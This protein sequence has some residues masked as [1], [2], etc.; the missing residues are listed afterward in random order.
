MSKIKKAAKGAL[1]KKTGLDIPTAL[2]LPKNAPYVSFDIFDTLIKRTVADPKDVFL[3]LEKKLGIPDFYK[4]RIDAEKEARRK[5]GGEV[6]LQEIYQSFGGL[7]ENEIKELSEEEL[8]TE[9]AVCIPNKQLMGFYRYCIKSKKV[10]LISD[11][12]LPREMIEKILYNCGVTGFDKIYI[13]CDIGLTKRSGKLYKFVLDDLCIVSKELV[14]IGND[15]MADYIS[16]KII[17]IN[18]VKIKTTA[19]HLNNA[20]LE[21][22]VDDQNYGG[23]FA[24]V[25]SIISNNNKDLQIDIA[26]IE[27]FDHKKSIALLRSYGSRVYSIGADCGKLKKQPIVYTK[28]KKL[29]TSKGYDCVHIHADTANK[30]LVS[31]LAAKSAGA[32]KIIL[33]SH[34]SGI[35]GGHRSVK[36]LA[37]KSCRRFLKYIGTELVSCSDAASKWMFP[38]AKAEKITV[39]NNGIDLEKYRFNDRVRKQVRAELGI[40]TEFLIGHVGRF[41][42]QKN[43]EYLIRIMKEVHKKEPNAKLL[44]IGAGEGE[45]AVKKQVHLLGLDSVV[46]FYGTSDR[47]NELMQAMDI[48]VLPSRFEGL[49]IVGV[50]AQAAGLPIVFSDKITRSAALTENASFC[51]ITP[52]CIE[53]WGQIILQLSADKAYRTKAYIKKKKRG[54]DIS[55]TVD[56]LFKL[57]RSEL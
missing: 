24:L 4:R 27:P 57:Y 18:A 31:G 56:S 7:S 20:V 47:V 13:S 15:F 54:F 28:L 45:A 37:H 41:N 1:D 43:H 17:G 11:M 33:H 19:D 30:L 25:K 12:Y 53:K 22:N 34:S 8:N 6:T 55:D 2:Q 52:D 42:Y 16:A 48:F 5:K 44:L 9:L 14:H 50:E 32:G 29:I 39:I 36:M 35:D 49:P 26:A 21:V 10:I 46:I 23:V 3:L 51:P 38:N 40:G